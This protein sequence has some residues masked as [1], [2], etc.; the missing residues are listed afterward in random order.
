MHPHPPKWLHCWAEHQ[1]FNFRFQAVHL[2]LIAMSK[3]ASSLQILT[4]VY[5]TL[6]KRIIFSDFHVGFWGSTCFCLKQTSN[7]SNMKSFMYGFHVSCESYQISFYEGKKSQPHLHLD[8][9]LQSSF[10]HVRWRPWKTTRAS[11]PQVSTFKWHA[12]SYPTIP[13]G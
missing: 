6:F 3:H 1:S 13:E 9:C 7:D 2:C 4:M 11:V 12:K 10:W 8:N 5:C